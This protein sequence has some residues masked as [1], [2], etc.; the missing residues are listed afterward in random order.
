MY[1]TKANIHI[2]L[3]S[4]SNQV[5]LTDEFSQLK[6]ILEDNTEDKITAGLD[7]ATRGKITISINLYS[8]F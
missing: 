4:N 5:E 2:I 8:L 1:G 7:S 6:K 3:F